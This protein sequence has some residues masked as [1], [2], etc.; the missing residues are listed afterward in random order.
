MTVQGEPLDCLESTQIVRYSNGHF[1]PGHDEAGFGITS[2]T[3]QRRH[4]AAI[5]SSAGNTEYSANKYQAVTSSDTSGTPD[6]TRKLA[7][8]LS[9]RLSSARGVATH[10]FAEPNSPVISMTETSD[11]RVWLG[12]RDKGLFYISQGRVISSGK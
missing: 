6:G 4:R 8:N 2:V 9:S 11:G 5:L 1:E 3:S 10:R 7:D 12:T